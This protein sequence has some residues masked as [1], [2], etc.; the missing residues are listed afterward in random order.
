MASRQVM[1]PR[2]AAIVTSFSP[3]PCQ[4]WHGYGVSNAH[5]GGGRGRCR[6]ASERTPLR[7]RR[8]CAAGGRQ[9]RRTYGTGA[10]EPAG[11]RLHISYFLF[12]AFEG[13]GKTRLGGKVRREEQLLS[14]AG[15]STDRDGTDEDRSEGGFHLPFP[16][17]PARP[18]LHGTRGHARSPRSAQ[19]G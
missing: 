16:L 13:G 3:L 5:R 15:M 9:D 2:I 8:R 17:A 7:G 18:E 6:R 1:I 10:E 19:A 11:H 14:R 4:A 12:L